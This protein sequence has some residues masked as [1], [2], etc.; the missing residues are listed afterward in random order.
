VDDSIDS[1]GEPIPTYE[2]TADM[3]ERAVTA[4]EEVEKI[5][6]QFD[7]LAEKSADIVKLDH[8]ENGINV[9]FA[10]EQKSNVT[11]NEDGTITI[12]AGGYY[13]PAIRYDVLSGTVLVGVK[14]SLAKH[15][16]VAFSAN[17]GSSV[18]PYLSTKTVNDIELLELKE[19]DRR[20]GYPY[21][22]L[23]IDNRT[24][25]E[26][27]IIEWIKT[28]QTAQ[29]N[30]LTTLY[31]STT[32][33]DN[34]DGTADKP[35]A[36]ITEALKKGA[37]KV[38]IYNGVYEEQI[39]FNGIEL[40]NN[41]LTLLPADT[42]ADV[43]FIAPNSMISETETAVEGYTRVYSTVTD[44]TFN[45]QNIWIFQDS[46]PDET[47]LIS[48]E[49]RHPLQ[50]GYEYRC[51]DTKIERCTA[52]ALTEAL[53]EIEA[54]EG[55]KWFW[56]NGTLYFSR[57]N[58]VT[59]VNPL[60]GSFDS[61]NFF[62]SNRPKNMSINIVGLKFKYMPLN[63]TYAKSV[64]VTDC[65]VSN[66]RAAGAFDYSYSSNVEFVRCEAE[67]CYTGTGG[68]G[69][70][71]HGTTSGQAY[72]KQV[73]ARLVDC[74][75][76]DNNDDGY[77]DHERSETQIYGGL[78]EYNKKG[79]VVP[80][81]GSHC[82]CYNVYSRKNYNGF[83]YTGSATAEEGGKYGQLI[84][85]NCVAENN[86]AGGTR[87]GFVVTQNGNSAILVNCKAIGNG[88]AYYA[89]GETA[90]MKL[91]DCGAIDNEQL[92]AGSGTFEIVNTTLVTE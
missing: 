25:T 56:D 41:E 75:S 91:I 26:P 2:Q 10:K 66:V 51:Q 67:R 46:I 59:S 55:Y 38:Y 28:V 64:R 9:D 57:P 17:G 71:A 13:F 4:L 77:S 33:N 11:L 14:S 21:I 42:E 24:G 16:D 90:R 31:V 32:G 6:P 54:A 35:L 48:D 84:C 73:T 44:K 79:G 89:Y 68:D 7:E 37:N 62:H 8:L 70:N 29:K 5:A 45:A 23:R 81:Y 22:I 15:I 36:T 49:E 86:T 19:A 60:R 74:W 1:D 12:A 27:I 63:T 40:L 88:T 43:T 53:A 76:H 34:N 65:K 83:V 58:A 78:Y 39:N 87:A 69:F 80:S 52:T 3:F 85:Y 47:T 50:R 72:S 92:K 61:L 82:S 18:T 30:P 20:N